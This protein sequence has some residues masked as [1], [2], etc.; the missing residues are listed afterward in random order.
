MIANAGPTDQTINATDNYITGSMLAV[1]GHL[2]IGTILRWRFSLTK[3]A[4]GTVTPQ[5]LMR[6]GAGGTVTDAARCSF[7]GAAQTASTDF[8]FI[9]VEAVIRATGATTVVQSALAFHHTKGASGFGGT[10]TGPQV[11]QVLS[12]QF[13][14]TPANTKVG[15]SCHPG[16]TGVWT[17]SVVTAEAL[18]IV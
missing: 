2:Q 4:T 3:T 17:F 1:S 5:L 18:N 9:D 7:T 8:G 16:A 10:A 12:S 13:D 6:W 15:F 14:A 11:L